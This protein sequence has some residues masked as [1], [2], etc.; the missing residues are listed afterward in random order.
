M[1]Q[2]IGVAVIVLGA[3]AFLVRHFF[4][5]PGKPKAATT[6][7]PLGKLKQKPPNDCH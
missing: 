7:I 2:E 4:G 3:V 5:G 1:V 6:F